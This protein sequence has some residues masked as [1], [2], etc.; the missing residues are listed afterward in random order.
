M[1]GI[2]LEGLQMTTIRC[3]EIPNVLEDEKHRKLC[4]L[5]TC[6]A[7]RMEDLQRQREKEIESLCF[8]MKIKQ[9]GWE[10]FEQRESLSS[11]PHNPV[12]ANY[13]KRC[14]W[15][16]GWKMARAESSE[17]EDQERFHELSHELLDQPLEIG[18]DPSALYDFI[19]DNW[20]ERHIT[21][22]LILLLDLPPEDAV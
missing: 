9:A 16:E 14:I 17:G 6:Y 1:T 12:F 10:A 3:R 21:D 5:D 7:D 11:N 18:Y 4:D 13:D 20:P 8:E 2:V 15:K 19:K 22:L